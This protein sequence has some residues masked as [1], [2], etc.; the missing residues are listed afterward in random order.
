M[1]RSGDE[2][3]RTQSGSNSDDLAKK[4]KVTNVD[5]EPQPQPQPQLHLMPLFP[6]IPPEAPPSSEE[7]PTTVNK[8]RRYVPKSKVYS[9][10]DYALWPAL[11]VNIYRSQVNIRNTDYASDYIRYWYN[12]HQ[13]LCTPPPKPPRSAYSIY[14]NEQKSAWFQTHGKWN[15]KKDSKKVGA[16]WKELSEDDKKVY[17]TKM[18]V[19][20]TQFNANN[21]F[22]HGKAVEW[23]L[24]KVQRLKASGEEF[25][26]KKRV[27]LRL[28]D[29]CV[30]EL[31]KPEED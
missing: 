18:D 28:N 14:F 1:K 11:A 10:K 13:G 24:E 3:E 7:K 26:P 4:Q 19:E 31:C 29:I 25:D 16:M 21:E 30:C 12:E 6:P 22:W 5:D 2:A 17:H 8:Q 23:R 27:A 9:P 15:M 20:R